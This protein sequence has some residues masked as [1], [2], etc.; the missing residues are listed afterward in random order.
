MKEMHLKQ[1][2]QFSPIAVL[3]ITLAGCGQS[4]PLYLPDEKVEPNQQQ[5]QASTEA[6]KPSSTTESKQD[7]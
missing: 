5:K 2:K 3:L 1:L 7:Q 6:V 4:G